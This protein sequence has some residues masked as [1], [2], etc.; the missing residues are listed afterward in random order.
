SHD[1][2]HHSRLA[3][4]IRAD[5]T[6]DFAGADLQRHVLHGD[7]AAKPLGQ[8]VDDEG[9]VV[10]RAHDGS[11]DFVSRP[12][13]PLGNSKTTMSAIANTTKFDKSPSGRKASL[14]AMRKSAPRTAPKIVRR[15]PSTAAMM[16]CTPTVMSIRVPTEAEPR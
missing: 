13:K 7:E 8:A 10:G 3:R 5:Q 4:S 2:L 1:E 16:I 14:I 12:K 15:P 9:G 6:E 11:F